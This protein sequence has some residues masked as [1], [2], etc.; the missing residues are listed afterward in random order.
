MEKPETQIEVLS[1]EFFYFLRGI[2]LVAIILVMQSVFTR[3]KQYLGK[4]KENISDNMPDPEPSNEDDKEDKGK[5]WWE[6][7]KSWLKRNE[8]IIVPVVFLT[9]GGIIYFFF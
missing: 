7:T 1:Q 8:D 3:V 4:K 9:V 6:K 2:Q 5:T